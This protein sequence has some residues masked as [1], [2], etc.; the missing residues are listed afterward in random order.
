VEHDAWVDAAVPAL[1]VAAGSLWVLAA[2]VGWG[3][4]FE[5]KPWAFSLEMGRHGA[6]VAIA[7]FMMLN[8][9]GRGVVLLAIVA[10]G[11]SAAALA[12]AQPA[13]A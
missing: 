6:G 1:V 4:L 9:V 7:L 5:G 13:A 10:G 8:G 2:L 11:L 3:A 12:R